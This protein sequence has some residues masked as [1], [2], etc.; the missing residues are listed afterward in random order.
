MKCPTTLAN[1][2]SKRGREF[3][4]I[5]INSPTQ[6]RQFYNRKKMRSFITT[7]GI[8]IATNFLAQNYCSTT[9]MQ[10][11]WFATHPQ[12]KI[13]FEKLQQQA[14]DLDRELFKNGYMKG[15]QEKGAAANYTIPVVFHILHTGGGENITDAQVQD[16][17]QILNE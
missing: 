6:F 4:T 7:V 1:S 11:E 15:A 9:E 17:V 2:E 12:D 13:Q 3:L 16:A 5:F 14:A 8:F 10:N